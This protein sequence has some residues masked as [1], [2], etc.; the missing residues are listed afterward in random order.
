[1]T[2]LHTI[3]L[4]YCVYTLLYYRGYVVSNFATGELHVEVY[5]CCRP[6]T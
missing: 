3:E 2:D 1:M 4:S 6:M 5:K